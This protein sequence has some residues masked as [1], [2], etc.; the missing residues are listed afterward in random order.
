MARLEDIKRDAVIKGIL[1]EGFV[2]VV[3][4]KWIG[5]AA[6]E[7]VYVIGGKISPVY[8]V[9]FVLELI[10]ISWWVSL[11]IRGFSNPEVC[12]LFDPTFHT[13]GLGEKE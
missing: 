11:Y 10:L 1:P 2:T 9:D 13:S 6:I 12:S 8:L 3:D 7:L 4:V 5:T